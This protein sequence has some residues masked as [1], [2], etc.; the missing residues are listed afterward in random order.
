MAYRKV[1]LV[2]M[3]FGIFSDGNIMSQAHSKHLSKY[4]QIINLERRKRTIGML[5]K[6]FLRYPIICEEAVRKK[7]YECT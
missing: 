3:K 5:I 2:V 4:V 7:P 6:C 1:R